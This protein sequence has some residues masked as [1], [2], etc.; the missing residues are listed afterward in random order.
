MTLNL[1]Q[2]QTPI[3]ETSGFALALRA[4]GYEERPAGT[5]TKTVPIRQSEFRPAPLLALGG[6]VRSLL[7]GAP[8]KELSVT[9]L[10][11]SRPLA[12]REL[13]VHVLAAG[14]PIDRI[15]E[16]YEQLLSLLETATP[17]IVTFKGASHIDLVVTSVT[18]TDA[19]GQ[20]GKAS[21]AVELQQIAGALR[22]LRERARIQGRK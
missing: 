14:A 21:F 22:C 6:A 15:N 3:R 18:R 11:A 1:V 13:K 20:A 7:F 16:F 5:Q 9:G 2:T 19:A 8:P 4:L 10:D 12:A 17:V